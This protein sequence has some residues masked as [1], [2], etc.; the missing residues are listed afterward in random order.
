[1]RNIQR[2]SR[3]QGTKNDYDGSTHTNPTAFCLQLGFFAGLIWGLVHWLL[4]ALN[5][6]K[7]M[8]AF[9]LDPFYKQSFL[10][11]WWGGLL[12]IAAFIVFSIIATFIYKVLLGRLFG[13]WP[14]ILYGMLW[15]ALI[16]MTIGPAMSMTKAYNLIGYKTLITECCLF[17]LWGLFIGYTIAFE[18]SDEAGREPAGAS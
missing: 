14:G 18:F 13:P 15:W 9:L 7:V 8:P 3:Q 5:F 17:V 12:G 11:K 16:F 2:S 6:T 4:F 1:M 10:L